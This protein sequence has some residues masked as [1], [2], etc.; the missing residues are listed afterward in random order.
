MSFTRVVSPLRINLLPVVL[1]CISFA[2][3]FLY[4][5]GL[6]CVLAKRV[7]MTPYKELPLWSLLQHDEEM[8]FNRQIALQLTGCNVGLCIRRYVFHESGVPSES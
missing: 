4:L 8:C 2:V 1:A 6:A 5:F 3:P 7:C